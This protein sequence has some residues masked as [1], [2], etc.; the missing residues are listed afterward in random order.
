M[1]KSEQ[2]AKSV[3]VMIRMTPADRLALGQKACDVKLKLPAYLIQCGL[4][5]KTRTAIDDHV[6]NELRMLGELQRT[7]FLAEA[8]D[9]RRCEAVVVAILGAIASLRSKR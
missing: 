6:I 8:R 9:E 2:R 7:I 4:G 3:Q 1:S 5:R